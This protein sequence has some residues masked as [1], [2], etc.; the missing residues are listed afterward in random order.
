MN[1][2]RLT[3]LI[4]LLCW[5][6]VSAQSSGALYE[7]PYASVQRSDET[8]TLRYDGRSARYVEGVG[9]L[10][11]YLNAAPRVV[12]DEVFVDASVLAYFGVELPKL[13]EVRFSK[14][15]AGSEATVTASRFGQNEVQN[16]R[17]VLDFSELGDTRGLER[18]QEEGEVREGERLELIL[19]RVLLPLDVPEEVYGLGLEL[20][21]TSIMT[22]L[23]LGG[24]IGEDASGEGGLG[25]D[26]LDRD[27]AAFRYRVFALEDPTRLVI[28]L[29]IE[30]VRDIPVFQIETPNTPTEEPS[31]RVGAPSSSE[32]SEEP[33][34]PSEQSEAE[35]DAQ[36]SE[37]TGE[38]WSAPPIEELALHPA[39]TQRRVTYPTL[40]GES[41]VDIIEIAPGYGEFRVVGESFV[42]RTLKELSVGS[43]AAINASYFDTNDLRTIGLLEIDNTLLSLPT[44]NRA[45][46]GFGFGNPVIDRIQATV[47]LRINTQVQRFGSSHDIQIYTA[48]GQEVG[49]PR[50]G[51]IVVQRGRVLMNKVGPRRVPSGG[52]VIAYQPD[53]R[54]LA[55][56]NTGDRVGVAADLFPSAFNFVEYAVEA[57]PLLVADGRAAYEPGL[58]AFSPNPLSNVNR[59]ASRAAVGLKEDGTVLFV[60]ATNMSARDLVPLF[61]SLGAERAL[62]MD[63]GGSSTLVGAG[64]VINRPP[65]SQRKIATAIIYV[66][67]DLGELGN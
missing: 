10:E 12:G 60:T 48:A 52:M 63:S 65:S 14:R 49:S 34:R 36:D 8:L 3:S 57:G 28:D 5:G 58:E 47:E 26:T 38:A 16:V 42:P 50:Q 62:Q 44:R 35:L 55:L 45:G 15:S 43:L 17:L 56:V 61:L 24:D 6:V 19:P 46:I 1:V 31:E 11:P 67:H 64:E 2:L 30:Q 41:R 9:W 33:P 25:E 59:P 66:P 22:R 20:N 51:A 53:L 4:F 13:T 21:T 37:A 39:V 40:L 54:A 18:L 32:S 29:E 7:L 23:D 27:S